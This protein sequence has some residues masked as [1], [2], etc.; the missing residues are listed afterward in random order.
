MTWSKNCRPQ[1]HAFCMIWRVLKI[2]SRKVS[3]QDGDMGRHR[4]YLLPQTRSLQLHMD[5]VSLK[6]KNPK[7]WLSDNYPSSKQEEIHMEIGNNGDIKPTPR[8]T[9]W[10]TTKTQNPELLPMRERAQTPHRT[11][12]LLGPAPE[13][14]APKCPNDENQ[15][16]SCPVM[17]KLQRSERH[18]LKGPCIRLPAPLGPV[19]RQHIKLLIMWRRLTCLKCWPER[20]APNLTHTSRNLPEHA[21]GMETGEAI[22][23]LSLCCAPEHQNIQEGGF[24]THLV[25]RSLWLWHGAAGA[26]GAGGPHDYLLW[27]LQICSHGIVIVHITQKG[28]YIPIF[29]GVATGHLN[30][31]WIWLTREGLTRP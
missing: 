17:H 2:Q 4:T 1:A 7:A 10:A 11:P 23:P 22:F 28:A 5:K 8:P 15:Q 25:P 19:Q 30:T 3:V 18:L 13:R 24:Y 9:Q 29:A 31:T 6:K 14:R 16:S 20:Q 12:Y 26:G 21:P 27:S